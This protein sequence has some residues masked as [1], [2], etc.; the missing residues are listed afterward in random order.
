MAHAIGIDLGTSEIRA[1]VYSA[2]GGEHPRA[3]LLRIGKREL[4]IPAAVGL[5]TDG[6]LVAGDRARRLQLTRPKSIIVAPLALLGARFDELDLQAWAPLRIVRDAHGDARVRIGERTFSPVQLVAAQLLDLRRRIEETSAEPLPPATLTIPPGLGN[7]ARRGLVDACTIAGIQLQRLVPATTAAALELQASGHLIDVDEPTLAICDLGGGSF[8]ASIVELRE[9]GLT[10]LSSSTEPR[11]GGLEIDRRLAE[12]LAEEAAIACEKPDIADDP[13]ALVRLRHA[14]ERAKIDLS[15]E[16]ERAV[17]LPFLSADAS[18]TKHLETALAQGELE[19]RIEDL[20]G[21]WISTLQRALAGSNRSLADL[22]DVLLVGRGAHVPLLQ[23]R[24]EA[25]LEREPN[26][27]WLDG[28]LAA[29]GAARLAAQLAGDPLIDP[30]ELDEVLGRP[31]TLERGAGEPPSPVQLP[32]P[33]A[34]ASWTDGTSP[35]EADDDDEADNEADDDDDDDTHG[36][37]E[38]DAN[39]ANDANDSHDDSSDGAAEAAF[40]NSAVDDAGTEGSPDAEDEPTPESKARAGLVLRRRAGEAPDPGSDSSSSADDDPEGLAEQAAPSAAEADLQVLDAGEPE[41]EDDRTDT[42]ADADERSASEDQPADPNEPGAE[43]DDSADR[44]PSSDTREAVSVP[45]LRLRARAPLTPH[46]A[47]LSDDEAADDE[48]TD[49]ASS[50]PAERSDVGAR[51]TDDEHIAGSSTDRAADAAPEER[52][53]ALSADTEAGAAEFTDTTPSETLEKSPR[54]GPDAA[55]DTPHDDIATAPTVGLAGTS[56][57]AEEPGASEDLATDAAERPVVQERE[58]G[59]SELLFPPTTT[60]PTSHTELFEA[61][62]DGATAHFYLH[63]G[64]RDRDPLGEYVLR[65]RT[66]I[67]MTF[68]VDANGILSLSFRESFRGKE[69]VLDVIGGGGMPPEEVEAL[70]QRER[71]IEEALRRQRQTQELTLRLKGAHERITKVLVDLE[72]GI[73]AGD[74]AQLKRV[75]PAIQDAVLTGSL[76]ALEAVDERLT[77]LLSELPRAVQEAITRPPED[78]QPGADDP[79]KDD[80]VKDDSAKHSPSQDHP[81]QDASTQDSGTSDSG[82]SDSGT[83]DTGTNDTEGGSSPKGNRGKNTRKNKRKNRRKNRASKGEAS[84]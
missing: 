39:D 79:T 16:R 54:E 36:A 81:S 69:A 73:P 65:G 8:S 78:A 35:D 6:S 61:D 3:A 51:D 62:G 59:E 34:F 55:P 23:D 22:S 72:A 67:D 64:P 83:S 5:D 68:R 56:T 43:A 46:R 31:I 14:S 9:G 49:D 45:G 21:R 70:A 66:A 37:G 77:T 48:A 11:V 1:A 42:G 76:S 12:R 75:L 84:Q 10:V 50:A 25:A 44:A 26:L 74:Q 33:R 29:L 27:R 38:T 58:R 2:I 32:L 63:E 60:L 52:S 28:D 82:M 13:V 57:D 18:G 19:E 7:L 20:V 24:L 47:L 15:S 53:D 4:R 30:V 40:A 41:A 80:L 17:H 71:A